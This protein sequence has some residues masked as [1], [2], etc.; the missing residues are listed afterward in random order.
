MPMKLPEI[1]LRSKKPEVHFSCLSHPGLVRDNNEDS[2]LSLPQLGLW[3]V[4]DGMGGHDNGEVASAIALT[5]LRRAIA[6]GTGLAGAIQQSHQDIQA[7]ARG[8]AHSG[9]MGATIVAAKMAAGCCQIAWVGDSRAYLWRSGLRRLTKD[10]SAVQMLLD[11]GLIDEW[12]ALDHPY[13]SVITQALG[14]AENAALNVDSVE[15]KFAKGDILLLCSDGL[16][17]EVPDGKIDGILAKDTTLE[18][19]AQEL[20]DAALANGGKDNVTVILL[21]I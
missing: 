3:A 12:Q 1:F 19:K 2:Y 13:R 8:H 14:G 15:T 7:E 6:A 16:N 9:N 10:H 21:A 20:V 18:E 11:Q 17:S 4:S 5:S